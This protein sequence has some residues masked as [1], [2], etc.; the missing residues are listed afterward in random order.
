[1]HSSSE[2]DRKEQAALAAQFLVGTAVVAAVVVLAD[3]SH[4]K[5]QH[6][7][8]RKESWLAQTG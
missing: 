3:H 8:R 1:M 4:S 7:D 5:M 6:W 2:Q